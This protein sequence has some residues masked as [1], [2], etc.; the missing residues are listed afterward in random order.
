MTHSAPTSYEDIKITE[1]FSETFNLLEH[2]HQNVFL[3]GKA[4]TGKSTFLEYFRDHTE[5]E[6]VVLA[7]TGVAALNVKGQTIHSFFRLKPGFVD[8][9][10]IKPNRQRLL[11]E[12]ELLI[13]D[14]IS[15]V[16]ADVFDGIDRSLRLAR[17]ND[18]PF[19]GVQICVIG[20]LF[21][22]P[23]VVSTKE[24]DFFAQH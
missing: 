3:T 22:L 13:I 4:G 1:E 7:P 20:D 19:G 23:P 9:A 16:R 2:T 10:A 6:V 18:K 14:E 15:M 12:L 5:K 11:K 21:Q 17:G 24:K 8:S